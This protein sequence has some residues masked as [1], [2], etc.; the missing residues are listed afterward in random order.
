MQRFGSGDGLVQ[1][2]GCRAFFEADDV[3]GDYFVGIRYRMAFL[4]CR[5]S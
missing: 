4:H 2:V 1:H 3:I 5:R